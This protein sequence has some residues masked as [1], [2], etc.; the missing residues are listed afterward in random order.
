MELVY[1]QGNP[2][3]EGESGLGGYSGGLTWDE[4]QGPMQNGMMETVWGGSN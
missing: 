3:L 1:L 2:K 4:M